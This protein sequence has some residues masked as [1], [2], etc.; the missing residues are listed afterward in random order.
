MATRP[1]E[2]FSMSEFESFK[3]EGTAYE[4]FSMDEF[5][6]SKDEGDSHESASSRNKDEI[7]CQWEVKLEG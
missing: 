2:P 6:Q 4:P 7:A 3:S 1:Y 5:N